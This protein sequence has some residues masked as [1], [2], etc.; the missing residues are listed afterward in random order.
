MARAIFGFSH[1]FRVP[2][3]VPGWTVEA[4]CRLS[5]S[6]VR[7][8]ARDFLHTGLWAANP[9]VLAAVERREGG[10]KDGYM[11]LTTRAITSRPPP[12]PRSTAVSTIAIARRS[13]LRALSD[14][15]GASDP[16]FSWFR[17]GSA[18]AHQADPHHCLSRDRRRRSLPRPGRE[19]RPPPQ[20]SRRWLRPRSIPR[21]DPRHSR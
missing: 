7:G 21:P 16:A 18:T 20:S 3:H 17:C 6:V 10:A 14:I 11:P 13:V 12:I 8:P 9:V 2:T 19:S 4:M 5:P 1:Y 15:G